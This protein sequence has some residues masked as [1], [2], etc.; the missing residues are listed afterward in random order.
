MP[1]YGE[2]HRC[3]SS[4]INFTETKHTFECWSHS[5]IIAGFTAEPLAVAVLGV[6]CLGAF[7]VVQAPE[8]VADLVRVDMVYQAF[9]VHHG[10]AHACGAV[11]N[12]PATSKRGVHRHVGHALSMSR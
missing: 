9:W 6:F 8:V 11:E 12:V 3:A 1:P 5:R 4:F 2:R 10:E 7:L